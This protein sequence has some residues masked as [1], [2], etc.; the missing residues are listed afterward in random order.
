MTGVLCV[1]GDSIANGMGSRGMSYARIVARELD[2]ELHD[3]SGRAMPITE[4]L[5]VLM[6]SPI[7]PDTAII[8]HGIT[9]AIPRPTPTMLRLVPP[10]WKRMGWMDPRPYFSKSRSKRILQVAESAVR[11]R[12]RNLLLRIGGSHTVMSLNEYQIALARLVDELR[13]RGSRVILLGPPDVDERFFP[14]ATKSERLYEETGRDLTVER[15][16]LTGLLDRRSD[17]LADGFH[18]NAAGHQKIA[19]VIVAHLRA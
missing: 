7:S 9:E 15:I 11:W 4:S 16:R 8:A 2:M 12:A 18:P 17:Y 13:S 5:E 14:G 19:A 10:R 3:F 6:A 1:F